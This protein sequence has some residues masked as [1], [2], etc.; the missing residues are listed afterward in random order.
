[1]IQF[2][3]HGGYFIDENPAE[4]DAPFFSISTKEAAGR[5]IYHL[6]LWFFAQILGNMS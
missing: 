5:F 1:M 4:F 6:N 3:C 2:S